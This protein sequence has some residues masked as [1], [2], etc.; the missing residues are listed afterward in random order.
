MLSRD[1]KYIKDAKQTSRNET[2]MAE[3]KKNAPYG[4]SNRSDT[5]DKNII[6]FSDI[7]LE[8]TQKETQ[9]KRKTENKSEQIFHELWNIFK[10]LNIHGVGIH[11][12]EGTDKIFKV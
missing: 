12:R 8:P 10:W 1:M 3:M 9:E 11:K 5:A 7:V 2:T 4:N 6:E